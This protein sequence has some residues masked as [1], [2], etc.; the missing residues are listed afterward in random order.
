MIS[1]ILNR[2]AAHQ[3]ESV[4][5]KL[6]ATPGEIGEAY[7]ALDLLDGG[8]IAIFDAECSIPNLRSYIIYSEFNDQESFEQLQ[9]L[10]QRIARMSR[11]EQMLFSG[12]IENESIHS[13]ADILSISEHLDRYVLLPHIDSDAALGRFLVDSGFKDCP[14]D[15]QA[16]LNL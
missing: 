11:K 14:E 16:Y 2:S 9:E 15:M 1:L 5:L 6:P 13:L 10:A 12:A 7:K 4:R 3:E 8:P